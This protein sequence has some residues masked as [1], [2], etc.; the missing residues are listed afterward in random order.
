VPTLCDRI[1]LFDT[2]IWEI[3]N[4]QWLNEISC[5]KNL[6]VKLEARMN[7]NELIS[8]SWITFLV[9]FIA[10]HTKDLSTKTSNFLNY[11]LL[12]CAVPV[13]MLVLIKGAAVRVSNNSYFLQ[14]FS[15]LCLRNVFGKNL[16]NSILWAHLI[17]N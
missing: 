12:S 9:A 10:K 2:T 16:M 6:N 8:N 3:I 7:R 14:I 15:N 11:L 5:A 4:I 17:F 1:K 13:V